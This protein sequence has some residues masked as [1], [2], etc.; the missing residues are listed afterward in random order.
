[1]QWFVAIGQNKL[2]RVVNTHV[3]ELDCDYTVINEQTAKLSLGYYER[4]STLSNH[5]TWF[6]NECRKACSI[7][8][9]H[10][11]TTCINYDVL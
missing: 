11:A 2:N 1:M 5:P 8:V 9:F 6:S 10:G 3:I 4:D 7:L